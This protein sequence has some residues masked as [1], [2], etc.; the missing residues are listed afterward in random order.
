MT[1]IDEVRLARL[2][3][4]RGVTMISVMLLV[5]SLMTLGILVVRNSVREVTQAGQLVAQERA[6]MVA[7]SAIDLAAGELRQSMKTISDLSP[8]LQG[9]NPQGQACATAEKDCIPG[10]EIKVPTGQRN[11]MLSGAPVDCGGHACMRQG[12]VVRLATEANPAPFNWCGAG[13][14]VA[15]NQILPNGDP[16]ARVCVWIR[17]N[18]A[19]ALGAGSS[20]NWVTETDGR[21]VLTAMA[22][23]RNTTITVEQEVALSG[24]QVVQPWKPQSP[25]EGYGG[26]HNN[27]NS[28]VSVC[29]DDTVTYKPGP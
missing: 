25:D 16:E 3:S 6:L 23:V 7:Q 29:A 28:S 27:D 20:G 9:S 4:Q 14:G 11:A 24:D 18:S 21:V 1:R 8:Y 12:A 5:I 10:D 17:N 2:A 22:T 13:G 26:G 19:D 15:F